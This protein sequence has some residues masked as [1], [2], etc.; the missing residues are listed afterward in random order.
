MLIPSL[1]EFYYSTNN[2]K[3]FMSC[4]FF[5]ILIGISIVLAFRTTEKKINIKDT[6]VI[7]TLSWPVLV[8]FA[9][10]PF[11]YGTDVKDFSEAFFEATSGLTTTGASIYN[12]VVINNEKSS[13]RADKVDYN[14]EQKNYQIS[15]Y[16]DERVKIKLIEWVDQKNSE[17]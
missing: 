13:L 12:N 14:F 2:T 4:S 17:F 7:T 6:I 15:M 1:F 9:S 3:T 16:G 8:L 5:T 10:L 11:Y